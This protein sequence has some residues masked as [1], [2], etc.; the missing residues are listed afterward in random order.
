MEVEEGVTFRV[1]GGIRQISR[2]RRNRDALEPRA[3]NSRMTGSLQR[4]C[5]E[6]SP[7]SER[8]KLNFA[9]GALIGQEALDVGNMKWRHS[10]RQICSRNGCARLLSAEC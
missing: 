8:A 2:R 7:G 3:K 5:R 10:P 6:P 1:R 4:C 9:V